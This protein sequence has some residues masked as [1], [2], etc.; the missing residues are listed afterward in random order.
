MSGSKYDDPRYNDHNYDD[1]L[2]SDI[3]KRGR[4]I[5]SDPDRFTWQANAR[6]EHGHEVHYESPRAVCFCALGAVLRANDEV[7][8]YQID[9]GLLE[10]L[11]EAAGELWKDPFG[12]KSDDPGANTVWVSDQGGHEVALKMYDLA[13][14]KA[15]AYEESW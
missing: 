3:L 8:E 15:V 12:G 7:R 4:E 10:Y 5:I 14:E 6:D 11:D 2:F 9:E 1:I 13:I